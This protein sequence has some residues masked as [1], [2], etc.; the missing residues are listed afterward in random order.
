MIANQNA[1][2]SLYLILMYQIKFPLPYQAIKFLG[3]QEYAIKVNLHPNQFG[4]KGW[5][6]IYELLYCFR[7]SNISEIRNTQ[8]DYWELYPCCINM[9]IHVS[10]SNSR[11]IWTFLSALW[12]CR[13]KKIYVF[14]VNESVNIAESG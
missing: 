8:K 11:F 9:A 14:K 4:P 12:C 6:F 13:N 1:S 3:T 7:N 10:L 2:A 5:V